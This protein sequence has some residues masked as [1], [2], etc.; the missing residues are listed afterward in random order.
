MTDRSISLSGASDGSSFLPDERGRW[1][2]FLARYK[3]R[4]ITVTAEAERVRRSKQA[5]DRYWARIVPFYQEWVGEDDKLQAHEDI[6][7][8][9]SK[10]TRILPTGEVIET[11]QRSRFKTVEEFQEFTKKA[12]RWLASHGVLIPD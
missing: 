8:Q 5:N 11:I 7:A 6:L 9:C 3:G 4:R 1:A 2:G 12:E 10:T